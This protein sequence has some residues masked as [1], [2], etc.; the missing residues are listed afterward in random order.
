MLFNN[1]YLYT[2]SIIV[3]LFCLVGFIYISYVS[4]FLV[5]KKF[6]DIDGGTYINQV[7]TDDFTKKLSE[8]LTKNCTNGTCEVQ[9]MLN[10][11][12]I[13]PYKINKSVARS[14]KNVVKN[15][16]GD[17]DDKSNLLISM[18]HM[19][20]YEA[21]FVFV[22]SHVF[23]VVNMNQKVL[24]KKALYLNNKPFYI[25][26]TTAK[27]SKIGFPFRYKLNE[28]KAIIDPFENKKVKINTIEYKS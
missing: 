11:A 21:Y 25:L 4:F 5:N 18:L 16:Y 7:K 14:G 1:K 24:N 2:L 26:E 17:C 8:E 23:I 19:Q 20:G 3:S 28:I 6:I 10:Y 22:P 13:I 15:N 9:K 12:S 27:N